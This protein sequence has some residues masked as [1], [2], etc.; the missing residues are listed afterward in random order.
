MPAG[1]DAYFKLQDKNKKL[2]E[3]LYNAIEE[4]EFHNRSYHHRTPKPL[5]DQLLKVRDENKDT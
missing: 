4:I 3:A 5:I 1:E 2:S